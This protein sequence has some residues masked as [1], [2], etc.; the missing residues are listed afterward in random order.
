MSRNWALAEGWAAG[1]L[2]HWGCWGRCWAKWMS[3]LTPL[4]LW[5]VG[6]LALSW[7]LVLEQA[8]HAGPE[9]TGCTSLEPGS[10]AQAHSYSSAARLVALGS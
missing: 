8:P 7:H 9:L 5:C 4:R 3:R 2:V 10:C 6:A 1:P